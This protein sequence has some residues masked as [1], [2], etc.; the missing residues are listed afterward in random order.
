VLSDP[1]AGSSSDNNLLLSKDTRA[2]RLELF[3]IAQ[4]VRG[5]NVPPAV[6]YCSDSVLN[7]E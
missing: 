2:V 5:M 7:P 6:L 1:W 4:F 3:N